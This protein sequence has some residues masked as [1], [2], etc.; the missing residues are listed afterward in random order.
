MAS[1]TVR[2]RNQGGQQTLRIRKSLLQVLQPRV[3]SDMTDRIRVSFMSRLQTVRPMSHSLLVQS[4]GRWSCE[5]GG[6]LLLASE[7]YVDF[8][9]HQ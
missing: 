8:L 6:K 3:I 7:T 4:P 2:V 1:S 5:P 9:G